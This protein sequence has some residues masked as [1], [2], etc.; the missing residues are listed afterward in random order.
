MFTVI[1][2]GR[3][4]V[5]YWDGAAWVSASRDAR[6][7]HD[8]HAA[9]AMWHA[10]SAAHPDSEVWLVMDWGQISERTLATTEDG[11]FPSFAS[12]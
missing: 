9:L 5:T 2:F 8:K 11:I 1:N 7:L 12:C 4:A 10:V 6:K 3:D